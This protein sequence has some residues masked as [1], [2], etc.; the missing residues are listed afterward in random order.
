[1][2]DT[3]GLPDAIFESAEA[4]DAYLTEVRER[5]VRR[6]RN[7][8]QRAFLRAAIE[9]VQVE[10]DATR[11]VGD[12]E[13]AADLAAV[14]GEFERRLQ[15]LDGDAGVGAPAVG[16]RVEAPPE[17]Q[18]PE[19]GALKAPEAE[20]PPEPQEPEPEALPQMS[21]E[22]REAAARPIL[23]AIERLS[24]KWEKLRGAGLAGSDGVVDRQRCFRVR[25]LA[26]AL[27]AEYARAGELG[28]EDL[29]RPAAI[30]LRNAIE[31]ERYCSGDG[32][33]CLP[34]SEDLWS[35]AGQRLSVE[36]WEALRQD[37]EETAEAQTAYEWF[38]A[39]E[40][41]L[42]KESSV[43]LL[44]A[45]AAVQQRLFRELKRHEGQDRMQAAL[46]GE[47]RE[48][49]RTLDYLSALNQNTSD[50][51]LDKLAAALPDLL[52]RYQADLKQAE[53][54]RAKQEARVAAIHGVAEWLKHAKAHGVSGEDLRRRAPELHSLLD[55]C[56]DA[57]V[58]PTNREL[59]EAL[60]ELGPTLL[61]GEAK[62]A[63]IY[64]AVMA[65]RKRRWPEKELEPEAE[66][67]EEPADSETALYLEVV[68]PFVEG[69]RVL[70]LGGQP[71]Q[72]V[73]DELSEK[74]GAADVQWLESKASDKAAKF[75]AEIKKA[76]VL[77]LAKNFAGHD[78][79]E[80]GRDWIRSVGGHFVFLP[81]GYG[82][83][84]IIYRL[85]QYVSKDTHT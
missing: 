5:R 69:K 70:I 81:S 85:Y 16:A 20:A 3:V 52:A 71:R 8:E 28:V 76:F 2:Q 79:S 73:C 21:E 78:M 23:D 48:R 18:E 51:E 62:Y 15:M 49:A 47:L 10:L 67:E 12:E 19:G 7:R 83:N 11:E 60:L 45:I 22:E 44:N 80:K 17:P 72:R 40:S 39:N 42:S 26:C 32:S 30:P 82:V 56:N 35:E 31:Q 27:G 4:L 77:L 66:P 36:D 43:A 74:L 1:M 65:E 64:D 84:Q 58:P 53:E 63:K 34:F 68:R 55:A 6:A 33:E 29:V 25:A 13:L 37:Y 59:R 54:K 46:Y 9:K 75:Q 14:L 57:G 41:A 38:A 50:G 24:D 61:D